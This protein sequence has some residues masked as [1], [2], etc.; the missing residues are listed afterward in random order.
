MA[1]LELRLAAVRDDTRPL[2]ARRAVAE[3]LEGL[4]KEFVLLGAE[5]RLARVCAVPVRRGAPGRPGCAIGDGDLPY[6][7]G[8]PVPP[9]EP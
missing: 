3:L 9:L 5:G 6:C 7:G 1:D 2:G 8:N 4:L